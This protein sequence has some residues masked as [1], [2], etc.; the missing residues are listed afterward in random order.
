MAD[1][2]VED[3]VS[4]IPEAKRI[5]VAIEVGKGIGF[6]AL[7][8]KL[9]LEQK[10]AVD[11]IEGPVMVIAGPGTGKT[12]I[13]T[14][15]IAN[16]LRQSQ[17]N[18]H[19][20][21]ALAFT[22][23]AATNMR[24][25][26]V[27]MIGQAGYGVHIN[28]F[29]GLANAIIAESG[30]NFYRTNRLLQIDEV[31]RYELVIQAINGRNNP[32]LRPPGQSE[33]FVN[34]VA[35]YISDLKR[36]EVSPE[37]LRALVKGEIKQIKADKGHYRGENLMV[38]WASEIERYQRTLALADVYEDYQERLAK[39]GWYDYDDMIL[40]V[41]KAFQSDQNLKLRYQEQF[42]YILID[43][44]QDTNNSQNQLLQLLTDFHEAP[45]LFVVGDDKQSIYRFQGASVANLYQFLHL[46]PT[47]K[48]INLKTNYRSGQRLLD[49]ADTLI[50]H[51]QNQLKQ[52][53]SLSSLITALKAYRESESEIT[54]ERYPTPDAELLGIG[55]QVK[56]LLQKGTPAAEIAILYRQNSDA[57]PFIDLFGRL[58]IPFIEERNDQILAMPEVK[59]LRTLLEVA[60]NPRSNQNEQ[61][62]FFFLHMDLNNIETGDLLKLALGRRGH[63][64]SALTEKGTPSSTFSASYGGLSNA[65]TKKTNLY[66]L[67]TK[68]NLTKLEISKPE[69]ILALK[70]KIDRWYK[71]QFNASLGETI[72]YILNDSGLL[73]SI[74]V[75]EDHVKRLEYLRAFFTSV[76]ETA[77]FS[78][79]PTLETFLEKLAIM[80]RYNLSMANGVA[81]SQVQAVRLLTAH[82]AKG[83]EFDT[84]F[85][86][87]AH[88]KGWNK[89]KRR[90]S[91][92]LPAGIVSE[93]I[94]PVEEEEER[95]LFFVAMTRARKKLIITHTKS[96]GSGK[97]LNP[98]S[99]IIEIGSQCQSIARLP[100]SLNATAFF[101]PLITKV[102]KETQKTLLDE[103]LHSYALAPTSLNTYL[104]C[105]QL[106]LYQNIYQIPAVRTGSQAYGEAIHR[107][108]EYL[109]RSLRENGKIPERESILAVF[110]NFLAS[111]GLT[112]NDE[113][114][115]RSRGESVLQA[116]LETEAPTWLK[117]LDLEYNFRPHQVRLDGT[118]PITGKLDKI[119][120]IPG[121]RLVRVVDYKTGSIRSRNAI[122]GQ[123]AAA[124]SDYWRQLQFYYVL[125]E[126]D[127]NFPYQI[128][129]VALVF[130]DNKAMFRTEVFTIEKRDREEMKQLIREVRHRILKQD[131]IHTPHKKKGY[132]EDGPNLCNR[133]AELMAR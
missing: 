17:M 39:E 65:S 1:L 52:L 77:K 6:D 56:E 100:Q 102:R 98:S 68:E 108:L 12:Q 15:R 55:E 37:R 104:Q 70:R 97:E 11:T 79:Y 109:G 18:P 38:K 61:A 101:A 63:P 60:H 113:Q 116:Y 58:G 81:E 110:Q 130:L 8:P 76:K 33:K 51:N 20:I 4:V 13:L 131:F 28:T 16:I 126:S 31:T 96:D 29:H 66:S 106:F 26:L 119:E 87:G 57:E 132:D 117:P 94:R 72:E 30:I 115:Y 24:E 118:I 62:L 23:N 71:K 48:V 92:P 124:D 89:Q 69:R 5:S 3:D 27:A 122:L 50:S 128:G 107:A 80:E 43:E 99:F 40:F 64:S 32:R 133:L 95:R 46:Y 88:E 7:Y 78:R 114:L 91:I 111:Q 22:E 34:E 120:P 10:L 90:E 36:E 121:S 74:M 42:Q 21:L 127:P 9:N 14:L 59:R 41:I 84:V 45:N 2:R 93:A 125:A 19:N 83:L 129:E 25:R 82:R 73:A 53:P 105:P 47:A 112:Q 44:Y 67:L 35:R 123:T 54:I 85:I 75:K 86:T 49:A 103:Q